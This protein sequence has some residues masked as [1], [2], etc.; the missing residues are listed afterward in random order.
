VSSD[1]K[2]GDRINRTFHCI[3]NE[4]DDKES[5]NSSDALSIYFVEDDEGNVSYNGYCFS[6]GQGFS[7]HHIHNSSHAEYLGIDGGEVKERKIFVFAP[8]A[9]PLTQEQLIELKNKIGF[10]DKAYRGLQPDWL[11]YFGHMVKL[12]NRG[13]PTEVYYPETTDNKV[14]GFKIRI[15]P[16]SF[17][18]VGRT[19]KSSQLSGQFRYKTGGKRLLVVGGE[20]D[21]VAAW[22][23]LKSYY[24]GKGQGEYESI[25]VVSGT[26]GE[27][28]LVQQ[29]AANYDFCDKYEEIY[30]G[31]DSDEAGEKAALEVCKVLPANKVKVVTW[32]LKDPHEMLEKGREKQFIRDFFNAK[33]FIDTGIRS[34]ADAGT[35]E[36]VDFLTA[37]KITLPDY[38]HRLQFNMRGGIRSSGAI[39][40]IVGDTSI[41]KSFFSDNLMMHWIFNSPLRPTVI[42][43]ERTGGELM[44]DLYSLYLKKNLTWFQDGHDAV[45]YLH[46]EE[47]KL[48]TEQ[49][50][51]DDEGKSRF[52]IIDERD[53]TVEVLKKQVDR[54]RK[55]FGSKLFIFDP[56]T[57]W[58]R[59]LALDQQENFFLWQKMMKKEGVVFVN[60]LHTRKPPTD[61]EGKMRNVSEYD[62][63]GTGSSIQ[64]ADINIVLN[65]NK[66][67]SDPIERNTSTVTMPKCRGGTTGEACRL[68]Y[69]PET[70]QQYDK[71]D[72]FST[73]RQVNPEYV[74]EPSEMSIYPDIDVSDD[75]VELDF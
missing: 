47:V 35:H 66:N 18:K 50:I 13:I 64:S 4:F 2:S 44:A 71:D 72:F 32:T 31:L 6:C 29:I 28:T 58:L 67:A 48:L 61:K 38:L 56:L 60:V 15:L 20:N 63:L 26:C 9:E 14:T 52:H 33:D 34:A 10:T 22:G 25:A 69:D 30:V 37:P 11:K 16:K 70:R 45:D 74:P 24:E 5:C 12:N 42:S 8:K 41:G 3:A 51:Y 1:K 46:K 73:P 40:N 17:T 57:D 21:K 27:G 68:Y 39:V 43:L 23:M 55:Q 59:S 19:G 53:G 49:M 65:R 75:V 54:A 62:V 7:S 36:V